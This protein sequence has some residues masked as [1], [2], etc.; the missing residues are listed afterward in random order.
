MTYELYQECLKAADERMK[1]NNGHEYIHV[2]KTRCQHCGASPKV[3]TRCRGW[4]QTFLNC[5]GVV[6]Q[7]KTIITNPKAQQKGQG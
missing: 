6:F 1:K 7:E 4:F 3:K 2:L 5:L